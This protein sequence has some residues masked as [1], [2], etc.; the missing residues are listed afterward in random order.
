MV[1]LLRNDQGPAMSNSELSKKRL[2]FSPSHSP[3]RQPLGQ[4]AL[5]R[6]DDKTHLFVVYWR[7]LWPL[8][9]Q[10]RPNNTIYKETIVVL[11]EYRCSTAVSQKRS[12]Q[13]EIRQLLAA[14]N[15]VFQTTLHKESIGLAC[16][17]SELLTC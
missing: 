5:R 11:K 7:H 16:T 14:L 12:V 4:S 13:I 8:V 6:S 10:T 1:N 2:L 17:V 15:Q 3:L 9:L